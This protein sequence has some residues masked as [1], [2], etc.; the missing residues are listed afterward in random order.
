LTGSN[1]RKPTDDSGPLSIGAVLGPHTRVEENALFP[2]MADDFPDHV[3]ALRAEHALIEGVL[4]ESTEGT[5]AD[6]GWPAR[7]A[8]ALHT[9]RDHVLKEQEGLFPAALASLGRPTGRP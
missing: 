8:D 9:L 4:A 3:E 6:P 5:P 1:T 2:P 7:L